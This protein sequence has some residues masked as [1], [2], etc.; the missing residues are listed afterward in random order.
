MV[1]RWLVRLLAGDLLWDAWY[2][3]FSE[4]VSALRRNAPHRDPARDE[5]FRWLGRR[6]DH[7][8]ENYHKH[9]WTPHLRDIVETERAEARMI[10]FELVNII[11]RHHGQSAVYPPKEPTTR[12]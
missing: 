8:D 10:F 3:G 4:A 7:H 5:F 1:R 11:R 6:L 9:Q 2:Q 12:D